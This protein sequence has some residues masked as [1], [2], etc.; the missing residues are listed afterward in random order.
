MAAPLRPREHTQE[1][2]CKEIANR[3]KLTSNPNAWPNFIGQCLSRRLRK[4]LFDTLASQ[5]YADAP[6]PGRK[7]VDV[8]LDYN[9]KNTAAMTDPL[10]TA[11]LESLLLSRKVSGADLLSSLYA[12]S[13]YRVENQ[14]NENSLSE[15]PESEKVS[16]DIES[17]VLEITARQIL[18]N[19]MPATPTEARGILAALAAWM[20]AVSNSSMH[21]A[22][23]QQTGNMYDTLGTLAIASLENPRIAGVIDQWSSKGKSLY[24]STA[25][26]AIGYP[27]RWLTHSLAMRG[28]LSQALSTFIDCWSQSASSRQSQNAARLAESM[29]LRVGLQLEPSAESQK[30]ALEVATVLQIETTPDLPIIHSRASNFIFLSSLVSCS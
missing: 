5:L 15:K 28:R 7:L 25:A 13:K 29:K 1:T 12:Q 14:G 4:E 27:R 10:I 3:R 2:Q 26:H 20:S 9:K 19:I 11:Y 8:L 6:I 24:R 21:L 22:L 18:K 17:V 23:D 30:D 16:N